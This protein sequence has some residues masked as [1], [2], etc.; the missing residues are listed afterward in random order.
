MDSLSELGLKYGTDKI[1]KHH[2]LPVYYDLYKN[3]AKRKRVKKVLE[4]GPAEGAGI[5]MFRDFFTNATIFGAEID[6]ER[7]D[8]LQGLDRIHV[9]QCDQSSFKDLLR[10]VDTT[11]R[12]IDLVID[13]GSHIPEHQLYTCLQLLPLLSKRAIYII[14]DVADKEVFKGIPNTWN[15]ELRR[16]GKRY[17][18]QL[19]I[20]RK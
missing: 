7:V 11:G 9:I 6:Q 1:G 16:V 19:I 5:K 17:D 12:D 14:E 10:L 15:K 2:Y 8:K 20:V 4:I 13:D 18:D 3:N